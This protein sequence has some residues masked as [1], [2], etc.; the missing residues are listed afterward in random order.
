MAP[1]R[2]T[3]PR[4]AAAGC[5]WEAEVEPNLAP[6]WVQDHL[7]TEHPVV[8][9]PRPP[10]LPLPKLNGQV[11]QEIFEEFSREWD[12]WLSSSNVE[13]DKAS[14]YLI[15]CC[16]TSLKTEIQAAVANVTK[17]ST[18]DVLAIMQKHAVL[19]RARSSMITELL[20]TRQAEGEPVLKFQSNVNAIA[21]NCNLVVPC[22]HQCCIDE[23]KANIPFT[24]IVVKHVVINGL[25]DVDI[26]REVLGTVDLDNK[27]L[28]ETIGI[29]ESKETALRSMSD[30]STAGT[31]AAAVSNYARQKKNPQTDQRLQMTGKCEACSKVFK[32]R[33][34]RQSKSKPDEIR[35]LKLCGECWADRRK[36]AGKGGTG[37]PAE[38]STA[39]NN[40]PVDGFLAVRDTAAGE[41]GK[42]Q[43]V[44]SRRTRR[45]RREKPERGTIVSPRQREG[46]RNSQISST[47]ESTDGAV[48]A[49]MWDSTR[50]WVQRSEGHG[51]VQL[52][53]YTVKE[54]YDRFGTKYAQVKPTEVTAIADSGCQSPIMGLKMLYRLGLKK[55]DLVRIKA[56]ATSISGTSI[57]II[58]VVMLRLS[59]TDKHSGKMA[60]TA[61]QVRVASNVEDFY[62]SKQMM[63]DLGIIGK[64]FPNVQVASV[65]TSSGKAS[66]GCPERSPAPPLPEKLPF[67]PTEENVG[68][69][70]AWILERYAASAFNQCT[71]VP[72]P[73]M[74]CEPIRIHIKP[75]AKPVAAHTA[76]TVPIHLREAVQK[77][78]D[79]DVALGILERVPIGTKTTWQARMHVVTKHDGTPRRTVDLRHLNDHCIRETEHVVP[80]YKQARLIPRNVWKTKTDAWNGYHSCPLDVR[81]RHLTTFITEKG[82]Y[83]YAAAP[84][85]FLASGDGYNQRYGRLIEDMERTT[86][87]VDDLAMWDEDLEGHWW[88]VIRYVDRIAK[89][90]IIISAKKFEFCEKEIEF[91]GFLIT[92]NEV[93]PLPKHLDAVA[94]FPRPTNITDMRSFFGLICQL[95]HN[96]KLCGLMAPFKPFLSPKVRFQWT[97]ELE[98]AFIQAK[99]EIVAAIK[100]GVEIFEPGRTT[101]LSP[102][103]SKTGIG[104]FLYQKYCACPSTVT[105]CCEHGWRVVLAG[106]RHLSAAEKNYWPTEGEALAV[107]WSLEDTKFFT[108]GCTD[109]HVQTDHKPLVKLLGDRTLDEIQNRRLVNLK[110]RTFPWAFRISWVAGKTIPAPDATSRHPQDRGGDNEATVMAA[111]LE[112]IRAEVREQDDLA[113]DQEMAAAA[114]TNMRQFRAVTWDIVKEET[115]VDHDMQ[116][117]IGVISDG[118]HYRLDELSR[119]VAKYWQ[120]REALYVVDGVVM[121]GERVVVPQR[122]R[123]EVL[124]SLHAAHQGVTQ[125]TARA[126]AAVFWPGISADIQRLRDDCQTCGKIAPSQRDTHPIPPVIPTAP[127]EAVCSD[128]F[129]LAGHHYLIVVDRLTNWADVRKA[130]PKTNEAGTQGLMDM[131]REV[132]R[133]YGVPV[134]IS[135]DGGP[136]Y[137]SREFGDF[138]RRWGVRHRQSAA[139]NAASNGRAEVAV[140]AV[141]RALREN[142][143]ANGDVDNDAVTRALLTM[144]NTPDRDSGHS[145]AQL[146]LGRPLRDTLPLHQ[147]WGRNES[148]VHRGVGAQPI[149]AVWHDMWDAQ[150]VALRQRLGKNI[151]KME[152]KAHD[153]RPLELQDHV[154]VQNQ[155]G[156][157]P[158]RW[159]RTG[160]VVGSDRAHDKY[161]VKMDGS[162][163]VTIRNR[164]FLRKFQPATVGLGDVEHPGQLQKQDQKQDQKQEQERRLETPEGRRP[165]SPAGPARDARIATPDTPA[166]GTPPTSPVGSPAPS[167]TDRTPARGR[168]PAPR[169]V[170]FNLEQGEA[171]PDRP[172]RQGT[173]CQGVPGRP[174]DEETRNR[175]Q[176]RQGTGTCQGVPG[177]QAG[178]H[179]TFADEAE[180]LPAQEPERPAAQGADRRPRRVRQQPAWMQSGDYDLEASAMCVRCCAVVGSS[181]VEGMSEYA[182][183]GRAGVTSRADAASCH[184]PPDSCG[185]NNV[186]SDRTEL[187][188]IVGR[189]VRDVVSAVIDH[190]GRANITDL[191]QS[192]PDFCD[193]N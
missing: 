60:E 7:A 38:D 165:G 80:P 127:F 151:E 14:G 180:P 47:V 33:M 31:G 184:S 128:Y 110:E 164:K 57:D 105:T 50:G 187:A 156:N 69:M 95:A 96:A 5:P 10:P 17:K 11:S 70:K 190:A 129:D 1:T 113:G 150:E 84:Q 73:M 117:L 191:G 15:N 114:S 87:C 79:E 159:E 67:E 153:L 42:W 108:L 118:F 30:Q 26:R 92:E 112:S 170:V 3:C 98:V 83:W 144:R 48:P 40:G 49:M 25:H 51:K 125:M 45:R 115:G 189:I 103:W 109:L 18:T 122:L 149:T 167:P 142:C 22:I 78:L 88:R 160:V 75:D 29:I 44:T 104:Y 85:G 185:R 146:L 107:A 152:T 121:L 43:T 36:K 46:T 126:A 171:P 8:Q 102:D 133:N 64:D 116:E 41:D 24:D 54:D 158:K 23:N 143:D 169:R 123:K 175:R 74:D 90:G 35:I 6:V 72:L 52:T 9:R 76:S 32:N 183:A 166:F 101:A 134:E 91:A 135:S 177:R 193:D 97:E 131:F 148:P 71:H 111:V 161:W 130:R 53:A 137:A 82:R 119:P 81:D 145:P 61:A 20:R 16:E 77:Q 39:V 58:G 132:F 63:R 94:K 59:G 147:P 162:R 21:R 179:V 168:T 173:A 172:V 86:R 141:K 106:S 66:C 182:E 155:H 188:D 89:N 93:K 13:A 4:A 34:L 100:E 181:S 139:Y 138:L 27:S 140:K 157:L 136:E 19:A 163:R 124:Q 28:A 120:H 62:L 55:R 99:K 174:T 56:T 154:R 178:R 12:N 65:S 192:L 68:R 186:V 2:V 37:K 176:V